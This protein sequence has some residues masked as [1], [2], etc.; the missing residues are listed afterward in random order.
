MWECPAHMVA[1][2]YNVYMQ[3]RADRYTDFDSL[4][5]L[6][7]TLYMLGSELWTKKGFQLFAWCTVKEILYS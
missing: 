1:V 4:S 2:D 6:E 3:R 7:M 5:N